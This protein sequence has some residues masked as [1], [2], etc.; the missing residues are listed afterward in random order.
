MYMRA[1]SWRERNRN[2]IE[3]YN[4]KAT[5]WK[6]CEIVFQSIFE[7]DTY[8]GVPQNLILQAFRF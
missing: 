3:E 1:D 7:V 2:C 5:Q 8:V 4:K 6:P